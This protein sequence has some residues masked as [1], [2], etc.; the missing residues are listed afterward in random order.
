V[1]L[2]IKGSGADNMDY[3]IHIIP[4]FFAAII[5]AAIMGVYIVPFLVESI[6]WMMLS[7]SDGDEDNKNKEEE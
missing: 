1:I 2:N 7:Q 4:V 6:N 5:A 3:V